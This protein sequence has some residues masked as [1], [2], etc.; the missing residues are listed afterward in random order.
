MNEELKLIESIIVHAEDE[1]TRR[2]WAEDDTGC[3]NLDRICDA[4]QRLK[5]LLKKHDVSVPEK[6]WD[7]M[8]EAQWKFL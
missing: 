6:Y 1:R 8:K 5:E 4:A 7:A 3:K 2:S